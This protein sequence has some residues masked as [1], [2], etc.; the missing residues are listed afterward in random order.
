MKPELTSAEPESGESSVVSPNEVLLTFWIGLAMLVLMV[1]QERAL[2]LL[3]SDDGEIPYLVWRLLWPT[4]LIVVGL[5]MPIRT[6]VAFLGFS[7]FLWS[8]VV[9]GD[10]AYFRFFGSVTSLV[11]LGTLGQLADVKDS[12]VDVLALSDWIFPVAFLAIASLS[13]LPERFLVGSGG[14][15]LDR[16]RRRRSAKVGLALLALLVAGA[17]VT[18][19]YEDTHHIGRDKWVMPHQHWG[20]RFANSTYASTFG[21]Y[22]YHVRDLFKVASFR[23]WRFALS[24]ERLATI[25]RVV[26]GKAA[27]NRIPAPLAGIAE[28]RRVVV[29]QLEAIVNWAMKLEHDGAPVMPFLSKLASQGLSWDYVF[30]VT[31]VGRTSD[32]EFAVMTGMLPD[33]S[34][35]NSF[36]HAD[37]ARSYL[38]RTMTELGYSTASYHGYKMSFWN[39][40]YTHPVYGFEDTFFQGAF[41]SDEVLGM[42]APDSVVYD[43]VADRIASEEKPS[44]S[45]I[46]S[47]SSH[48][49][50]IYTP[51]EY[52]GLFADLAPEDGWGLLGPYLR[53][54]RYTDDA[55]AAFFA[56]MEEQ[57]LLEDTIFLIYGDHDTGALHASRTL[58]EMSPYAYT[59][60]EERVPFVV[61]VP[62]EE[63]ELAVHREAHTDATAGL[64]DVFPTLMH[65]LGEPVPE[66]V[67]G[68]NLLVPDRYRE[69]VPLLSMAGDI[70]FAFR[71]CIHTTRG[72][73]CVDPEAAKERPPIERLPSLVQGYRDQIIVRDLLEHPEYWDRP[74]DGAAVAAYGVGVAP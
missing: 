23:R 34:R 67:L 27:L 6:R 46:I 37:R 45:F 62:G 53:S 57:G 56:R 5:A 29:I 63:E 20:S 28:G 17:W 55:L 15:A 42:G 47:L 50:F 33:T 21:L 68:T 22:N 58:P 40:I 52:D 3:L 61:V 54:A 49:P 19:I 24:E 7:G 64:H 18:P 74:R 32:A 66:G 13:L 60:A 51:P 4:L 16:D 30:D 70:L 12:V 36:A 14:R 25:D 9:V 39:R 10:M 41:D 26:E 71:G 43:F 65:L 2:L 59:I 1:W 72:S 48:H 69:P 8:L 11:S 31:S 38:P 35:P 73:A 44:F